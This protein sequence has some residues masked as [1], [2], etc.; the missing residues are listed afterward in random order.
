MK[1]WNR[2]RVRS[3]ASYKAEERPIEFVVNER[4]VKV[5]SILESWREPDFIY[6]KVEA[7]DRRKYILRYHEHEDHWEMRELG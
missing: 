5:R 2:T 4:E 3:L 1:S 7:D 6:F